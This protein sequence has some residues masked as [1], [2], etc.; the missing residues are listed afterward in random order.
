MAVLDRRIAYVILEGGL[1]GGELGEL[2]VPRS[3]A[4]M[5]SVQMEM[6]RRSWHDCVLVVDEVARR[7]PDISLNARVHAS[8]EGVHVRMV[9]PPN[10]AVEG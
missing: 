10:D 8:D 7:E 3:E 6:C 5:G 1:V 9:A 4:A 2:Y